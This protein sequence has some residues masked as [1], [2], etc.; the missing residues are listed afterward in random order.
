MKT[1]TKVVAVV[2]V[3]VMM[4][5]VLVSCAGNGLSGKYTATYETEGLFGIGAASYTTT[6]E[7]KGNKVIK[8]DEVTVGDK[9]TTTTTN[10]T[11]EIEEDQII[12]TWDKN[13]ETN[14]N[15]DSITSTNKYEFTKGDDFIYIGSQKYT[16]A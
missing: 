4:C 2:L 8:T 5:A 10:G 6:Y 11:Y 16:K 1:M 13:V 9:T 15:G 7:F 3:A 14:E 12:F